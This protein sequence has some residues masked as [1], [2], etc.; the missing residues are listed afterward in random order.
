MGNIRSKVWVKKST[1]KR[2]FIAI[3]IPPFWQ[4]AL[5]DYQ[6]EAQRRQ[7]TGNIPTRWTGRENFHIT[8]RFIGNV[9]GG[10]ISKMI[11]TF[12]E[13]LGS[14]HPLSLPYAQFEVA[15]PIDPKMIWA[16]FTN[17]QEFQALVRQCT[18]TIAQFLR[19]ECNGAKLH[20]GHAVVPHV[21]VA[22]LKGKVDHAGKLDASVRLPDAL[23]VRSL[24]LYESK[25]F[26]SGSVYRTIATFHLVS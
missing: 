11:E 12:R 25:T 5:V 10:C 1:T 17:T 3:P 7:I 24:M 16:R 13:L 2:L 21:T 23:P 14:V 4:Q 20:N 8:V 22:R 15:T 19:N 9:E 18:K 26:P 6:K